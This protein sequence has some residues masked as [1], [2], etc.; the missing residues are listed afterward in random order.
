MQGDP[1]AP[2][3]A[4]EGDIKMEYLSWLIVHFKYS[5]NNKKL[6]ART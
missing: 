2:E 3:P 5:S 4:A 6:L 1:D